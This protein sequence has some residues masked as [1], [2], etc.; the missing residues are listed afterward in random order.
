MLSDGVTDAIVS[1]KDDILT[2]RFYPDENKAP[3]ILTQGKIGLGRTFPVGSQIQ[4]AVTISA[5][6]IS[7]EF[8][9]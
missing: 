8:S 5:E 9:S 7:A 3:Y 4:A 6:A 1:N 2:V